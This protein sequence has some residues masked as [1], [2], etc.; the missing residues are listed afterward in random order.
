MA[1]LAYKRINKPRI[2]ETGKRHGRLVGIRRIEGREWLWK[3]DCGTEKV[4]NATLVR[5]GN[6]A[7]CGCLRS[8]K[9]A[10]R[11]TKHGLTKTGSIAYQRWESI[12]SRVTAKTGAKFRDYASRG[13]TMCAE[14]L[15]DPA[16]FVAHIGE[17]PSPEWTVDR[18]D[19]SRG[20]EPGNVRWAT[21]LEQANNKTN[22][23]FVEYHGERITLSEM[24]RRRAADEGVTESV[25]R[26]RVERE[27]YYQK[28]AE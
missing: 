10:E 2:D 14:W 5:I 11:K 16:A 26:S 18:I 4:I 21:K 8:E 19:N 7:S 1:K 13:V 28:R 22:N 3:C 17:P 24:I 20:Y 15:N 23:R 12:R 25:M 6:T 27:L 9:S